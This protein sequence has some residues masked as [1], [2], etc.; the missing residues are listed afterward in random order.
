VADECLDDLIKWLQTGGGQVAIFDGNNVT[1]ARR[2]QIHDKLLDN[3]IHVRYASQVNVF[4]VLTHPWRIALI[5]G[6][7]L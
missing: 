2:K 3:E 7:H 4:I 6:I 5:L 1:E